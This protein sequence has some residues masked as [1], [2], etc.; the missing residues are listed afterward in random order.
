MEKDRDEMLELL[1]TFAEGISRMF[2][3]NCETLIQDISQKSHPILAIY[4]G[5]VSGR[6]VGSIK[7]IF[8]NSSGIADLTLLDEKYINNL[9]IRGEQKMKSTTFHVRGSDY[10]YALGINFD[11]TDIANS[12]SA[13]NDLISAEVHLDSAISGARQ[14]RLE[15]I[16]N[17]CIKLIG[18]NPEDMK[19]RD[20]LALIFL[21][22]DEHVFDVQKSVPFISE[23]LGVSRFTIYNYIKEAEAL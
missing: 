8:G 1:C 14:Q 13:I 23:K 9:V 21:L 22:K 7:D 17:K 5:H 3:K 18:K 11:F 2:G 12:A 15:D 4:N 16:F 19:K 6:N 20:R 10:F